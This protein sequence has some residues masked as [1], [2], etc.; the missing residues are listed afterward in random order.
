MVLW[1]KTHLQ[2]GVLFE[3]TSFFSRNPKLFLKTNFF[4]RNN[5]HSSSLQCSLSNKLARILS[6][7]LWPGEKIIKRNFSHLI[8]H[9]RWPFHNWQTTFYSDKLITKAKVRTPSEPFKRLEKQTQATVFDLGLSSL[10]DWRCCYAVYRH[11]LTYTN[12]SLASQA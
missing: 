10:A 2:R 6:L 7:S 9:R 11:K 3:A 4:A 1:R 8:L 12:I 5:L